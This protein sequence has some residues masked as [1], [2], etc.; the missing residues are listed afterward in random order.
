M[1]TILHDF[2]VVVAV[3]VVRTCPRA[4]LL[5][6]ITMRKSVNGL[7]F[8]PIWVWGSTWWPFRPLELHYNFMIVHVC[9]QDLTFRKKPWSQLVPSF[10]I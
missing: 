10:Q 1:G 7:P 6:I 8:F 2:V 5:A 9:T 4:I 3:V